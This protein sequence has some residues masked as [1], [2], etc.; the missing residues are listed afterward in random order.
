MIT[1][2]SVIVIVVGNALTVI[3]MIT[4]H[5]PLMWNK[6]RQV[7]HSIRFNS[8]LA[9]FGGNLLANILAKSK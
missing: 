7:L 4:D 3:T 9:F 6:K 5:V 8:K 2:E 1:A